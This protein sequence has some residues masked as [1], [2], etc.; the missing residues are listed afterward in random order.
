MSKYGRKICC[1]FNTCLKCIMLFEGNK[2]CVFD[3][4]TEEQEEKGDFQLGI[5]S[6]LPEPEYDD[7]TDALKKEG[8]GIKKRWK[9]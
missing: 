6:L 4:T 8:F 3:E 9:G 1:N 7:V 2:L 5:C